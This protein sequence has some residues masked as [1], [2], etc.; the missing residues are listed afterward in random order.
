MEKSKNS[1]YLNLTLNFMQ[2]LG[3]ILG[4]I[5]RLGQPGGPG[6]KKYSTLSALVSYR[7]QFLKGVLKTVFLHFWGP[8][9]VNMCLT[10]SGIFFYLARHD[11][12][13][14][15][16]TRRLE[17]RF[18]RFRPKSLEKCHFQGNGCAEASLGSGNPVDGLV[19]L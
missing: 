7:P 6:Q 18:S 13:K 12:P 3:T 16:T 2:K 4:S 11:W 19:S 1:R 17:P 8:T 9:T 5:R 14:K 10:P 15:F